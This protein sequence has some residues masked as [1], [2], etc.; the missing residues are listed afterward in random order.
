MN[1]VAEE[2]SAE[3]QS[4]AVVNARV[5][6]PLDT[7]VLDEISD[8][9]IITL[10]ENSKS[11]GF[12]SAVLTYYADN[13]VKADITVCGVKDAFVKHASVKTQ[14]EDN[15]LDKQSILEILEQ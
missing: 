6:K 8:K 9:K 10:E 3:V 5:V 11:G 14:L 7:K 13:G 12:G 4:V 2:I 15:R 1:A